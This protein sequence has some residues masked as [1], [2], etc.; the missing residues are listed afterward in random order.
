MG[1]RLSPRARLA[2]LAG[3]PEGEPAPAAETG[4]GG[5]GEE[6]PADAPATTALPRPRRS[7][8]QGGARA[9][10]VAA[11]L[12][13][14]V[15]EPS[16]LAVPAQSAEPARPAEPGSAAANDAAGVDPAG[17]PALA[18]GAA[19]ESEPDDAAA[20]LDDGDGSDLPPE[21]SPRG[22]NDERRRRGLARALLLGLAGIVS[23]ALFLVIGLGYGATKY[24]D[25]R[26]DRTDLSDGDVE[27][28]RPPQIPH[29]REVWLLVGSDVRTGSDAAD[30]GG[31]RS[32][33]MMIA[34]L[35]ADEKT[36]LV[37]IPRDLKV[38][39]P[40][41]TD[42]KGKRH[43]ARTNRVNAAFNDGGPALL[44]RT[45]E[46]VTNLRIDHFA[47]IDFNGFRTMSSVLGGVE[48]C[49]V[50]DPYRDPFKDDQGRR[51][52]STN[53]DDSMSGFHGKEGV[54]LLSGD[55]ALA[56]VRQ[57]H[58]FPNGDYTR[59]Q[60][61]QA[62]LAAVFRK[63][64]SGDLLTNPG[65][66]TGFLNAVTES[67]TVDSGTDLNDLKVLAERMQA[68]SAGQVTFTTIPLSGA[69]SGSGQA[70]YALYDPATV[71][72]FF[73]SIVSETGGQGS[74]GTGPTAPTAA[75]TPIV[76]PS[77]V[78]VRVLNGTTT[79]GIAKTVASKLR[80]AGY[81]V[82]GYG[83]ADDRN[84]AQT[85]VRFAPG[86]AAAANRLVADVSG[87]RALSGAGSGAAGEIVLVV[88]NDLVDGD[89]AVIASPAARASAGTAAT[90]FYTQAPVSA[91]NRCVK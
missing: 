3:G 18:G 58:G 39:I 34:Y 54:N 48:V 29:G 17:G 23:C 8:A 14:P 32:D 91:D 88:G 16:Q 86:D 59:V 6:R 4:P 90:P 31:A 2:R 76:A 40:A 81:D 52:V 15:T 61:Q 89:T 63:V 5:D 25:S 38:R 74:A 26:V 33:T 65:K 35:G 75:P 57:R 20:E 41:Y 36:T 12:P 87:A 51:R 64:K 78:R 46:D 43:A 9:A 53:L 42:S 24:Y 45:L 7:L 13:G 85:E 47:E 22:E 44:L 62:F 30:V 27:G 60:R 71:R 10:R 83:V 67:V 77:Q 70:Y 21:L 79:G 55:N 19:G 72:A 82:V 56:F 84:Q 49:M 69:T 37:S 28:T 80:N 68:M 1:E 11:A 73:A 66:L 50:K